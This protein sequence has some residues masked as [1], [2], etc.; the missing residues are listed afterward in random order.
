MDMRSQ[1]Y[2]SPY[3]DT[4]FKI[5]WD[6]ERLYIGAFIQE[7]NLWATMTEHDSK[8]W[9]ENGFEVLMDVD[10][11]M[12][13]YKQAQ[14]N[15]LGT[16]MDQLRFKSYHDGP[17]PYSDIDWHPDARKEVFV[18]GTVNKPGDEDR[19]WTVEMSFSFKSLAA[20]STRNQIEPSENEV[21]FMQ[22]GRSE[23]SLTVNRQGYYEKRPNTTAKWWSWQ[24]CGTVNL[25]L[26]DRWGLVQF[27]TDS[28]DKAFVFQKWHIYKALFDLFNALKS[29]QALNGKYVTTVDEL[30]V[31]PYLLSRTCV[32]I[33]EV[34]LIRT[35]NSTGFVGTVRSM[36]L[37]HKPAH[38]SDDRY[39]WFE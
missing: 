24:P 19:F 35:G 11:S 22:F 34:K 28:N 16:M 29:Y 1:I 33:P 38:I 30:D 14:I 5:R 31:P 3:L 8:L 37:S 13:N 17:G 21:W 15:V 12:Y 20:E 23:Q 10:G 7:K 6:H 39:I 26:V 36:Y 2:R 32:D 9:Q 4:K 18:E 25:H 27:K